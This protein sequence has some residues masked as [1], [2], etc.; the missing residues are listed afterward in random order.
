MSHQFDNLC[1]HMEKICDMGGGGG[2]DV[3][4]E[5]VWREVSVGKC[6]GGNVGGGG[7]MS[8]SRKLFN[9]Y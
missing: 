9:I 3:W 5:N 4:E 8:G 7:R 2:W 1:Y 6:F